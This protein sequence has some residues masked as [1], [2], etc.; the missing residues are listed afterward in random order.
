MLTL[1]FIFFITM[2][3][4]GCI[5]AI[6]TRSRK[7]KDASFSPYPEIVITDEERALYNNDREEYY[8]QSGLYTEKEIRMK[9]KHEKEHDQYIQKLLDDSENLLRSTK[10]K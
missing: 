2:L 9:L 3:L 4:V 5:Y 10:E 8:R 6:R 7:I 1:F